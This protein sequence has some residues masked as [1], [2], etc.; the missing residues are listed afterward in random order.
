MGGISDKD[1][2]NY[3]ENN[4]ISSELPEGGSGYSS[5]GLKAAMDSVVIRNNVFWSNDEAIRMMR[6]CHLIV[7]HNTFYDNGLTITNL[8]ETGSM[9]FVGNTIS[10]AKKES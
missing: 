4:L 9:H 2:T 5:Y 8:L 10:E 3:I 1:A 7:E 6:M